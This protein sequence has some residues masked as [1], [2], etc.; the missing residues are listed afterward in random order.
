MKAPKKRRRRKKRVL[1]ELTGRKKRVRHGARKNRVRH[2]EMQK[3]HFVTIRKLGSGG[4]RR[5]TRISNRGV[6]I[7]KAVAS[8]E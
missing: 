2:G 7:R 8:G 1:Q 5:V 3:P 6:T 4:I